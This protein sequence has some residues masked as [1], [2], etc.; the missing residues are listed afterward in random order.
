[1]YLRILLT[2]EGFGLKQSRQRHF[3]IAGRTPRAVGAVVVACALLAVNASIASA[4]SYSQNFESVCTGSNSNCPSLV[5]AGWVVSM[6]TNKS[7]APGTTGW[8]QGNPDESQYFGAQSGTPSSYIAANFASAGDNPGGMDTISN[9]LFTPS[10]TLQ[11]G[12]KISFWARTL[13]NV[14]R[15][16]R[17]EFRLS[18]AGTGT[19]VGSSATTVGTYTNKIFDINSTYT[20]DG[21]PSVWTY[22][23]HILT[24]ADVPTMPTPGRFGFRYFVEDGGPGGAR[25][26]YIG[27]DN[28]QYIQAPEPSALAFFAFGLSLLRRRR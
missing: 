25:S 2:R 18:L 16:D 27:I 8:F 1:M 17:L 10:R 26:D 4:Q 21:F 12:D 7:D 9:W 19:F 5:G 6:T 15:P 13:T 11:A 3:Q 14:V 22:Y 23:E 20:L 28:F 24:M